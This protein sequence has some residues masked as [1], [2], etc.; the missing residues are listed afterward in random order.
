MGVVLCVSG[1]AASSA[2]LEA[3]PSLWQLVCI[4]L[5]GSGAMAGFLLAPPGQPVVSAHAAITTTE[6][7]KKL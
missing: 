2:G 1:M 3:P 5:V 4:L 7:Q 6:G